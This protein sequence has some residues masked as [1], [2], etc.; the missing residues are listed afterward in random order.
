MTLRTAGSN[1]LRILAN[2]NV[3]IGTT[4]PVHKLDVVGITDSDGYV[5]NSA[6]FKKSF[7]VG[8]IN[9]GATSA[10]GQL[11]FG[12]VYTHH[13]KVIL[14]SYSGSKTFEF[15]GY[16]VGL[17]KITYGIN[18]QTGRYSDIDVIVET[19]VDG[20]NQITGVKIAIENSSSG[21]DYVIALQ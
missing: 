17:G 19:I 6:S 20:T 4:N 21:A 16:Q 3:G 15:H 14:S 7:I 5:N 18:S 1:R 11:N 9:A 2:G 13:F 10:L 8:N 12:T